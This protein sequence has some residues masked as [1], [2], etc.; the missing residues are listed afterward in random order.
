MTTLATMPN[1]FLPSHCDGFINWNTKLTDYNILNTPYNKDIFGEVA[2][3]F[4][5]RG[6]RVGAYVCPSLWNNDKYGTRELPPI[7][8]TFLLPRP[9]SYWAPNATNSLGPVCAPNY[10]PQ[11]WL[12]G[13]P[14]PQPH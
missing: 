14:S 6:I 13:F 5:K 8:L 3:A 12:P 9:C 11:S 4:R 1:L 2:A 10:D 7:F